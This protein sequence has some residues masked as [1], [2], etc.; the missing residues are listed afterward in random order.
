MF[1][2]SSCKTNNLNYINATNQ[3]VRESV[4]A[5]VSSSGTG[6]FSS[7][8][9]VEEVSQKKILYAMGIFFCNISSTLNSTTYIEKKLN[10]KKTIIVHPVPMQH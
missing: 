9:L 1:K 8:T 10:A 5:R 3:S 6:A 2:P 4:W 7:A